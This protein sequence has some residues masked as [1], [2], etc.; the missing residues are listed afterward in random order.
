MHR[1][2]LGMENVDTPASRLE[3]SSRCRGARS[4]TSHY[5]E[6]RSV[7]LRRMKL[8]LE[9]LH[10]LHEAEARAAE[11]WQELER[12]RLQTEIRLAEAS[13][14]FDEERHGRNSALSRSELQRRNFGQGPLKRTAGWVEKMSVLDPVD[15]LPL[16]VDERHSSLSKLP[17]RRSPVVARTDDVAATTGKSLFMERALDYQSSTSQSSTMGPQ[18][19]TGDFDH[20][21]SMRSTTFQP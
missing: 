9:S 19:S 12:I 11:I 2:G 10:R 15:H 20:C 3:G 18:R 7:S 5:T 21:F 8:E 16:F 13:N 1:S 4:A 6:A 14:R 17:A